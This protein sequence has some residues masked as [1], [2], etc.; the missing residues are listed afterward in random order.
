MKK[1]EFCGAFFRGKSKK[2]SRE[3]A[4]LRMKNNFP[5]KVGNFLSFSLANFDMLQ[6][7]DRHHE[8]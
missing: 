7:R 3:M 5:I 8:I 6:G 4:L 2:K 1:I